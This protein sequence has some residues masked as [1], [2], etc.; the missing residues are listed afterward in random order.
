[1]SLNIKKI[2]IGTVQFS[3]KYGFNQQKVS[4]YQIKK[5]LA[6]LKKQKIFFIDEAISYNFLKFAHK[7]KFNLSKHKIITKIPL[8]QNSKQ[9]LKISKILVYNLKKNNINKYHCVLL[10]DTINISSN[11]IKKNINYLKKLKKKKITSYIGVSVYNLKDFF[12]IT[13]IYK[14]DIAQVPINIVDRDFLSKKFITYVKKNNVKVHARSI[15]LKGSLL[16]KKTD[17]SKINKIIKFLNLKCKIYGISKVNALLSFILNLKFIDKIIVGVAD[18][19]QLK[20]IVQCKIIK[21]KKMNFL[22]SKLILELKTLFM[23]IK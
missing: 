18:L 11:K 15:F 21:F 19:D 17:Y 2:V 7:N 9:F 8:I 13:K 10:H 16:Q 20:Q 1:M 5:I 23:E 6:Y 4:V 22:I 14:P 12:K 3:K